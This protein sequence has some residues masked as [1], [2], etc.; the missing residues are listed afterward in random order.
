[1]RLKLNEKKKYVP[2]SSVGITLKIPSNMCG[3][4]RG[5]VLIIERERDFLSLAS[6]ILDIFSQV[7][8]LA[9]QHNAQTFTTS[10]G[11]MTK[12]EDS[13]INVNKVL[14]LRHLKKAILWE[15]KCRTFV[16]F[17]VNNSIPNFVV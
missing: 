3:V 10:D 16:L 6:H 8:F 14:L 15:W 7:H 1:M 17:H 11:S 2:L 4:L 12:K 13:W 9:I 5:S